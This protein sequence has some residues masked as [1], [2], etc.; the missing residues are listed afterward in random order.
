M[1]LN[2]RGHS[3]I[4]KHD[5]YIFPEQVIYI[6]EI[7]HATD[8]KIFRN[9]LQSGMLEQGGTWGGGQQLKEREIVL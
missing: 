4:I 9:I 1:Y 7:C 2:L 5:I 3:K 6:V 8:C